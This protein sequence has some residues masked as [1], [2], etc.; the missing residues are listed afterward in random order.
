MK[1]IEKGA[2]NEVVGEE[3]KEEGPAVEPIINWELPANEAGVD[4]DTDDE[5]EQVKK[6]TGGW[7]LP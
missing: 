4:V 7:Q 1:E 5:V 3:N 2:T 6:G